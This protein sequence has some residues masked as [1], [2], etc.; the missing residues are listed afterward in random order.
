MSTSFINDPQC[1]S[2][3]SQTSSTDRP[4]LVKAEN[5][6][7]IFCRDLKKSLMYGLK[8]SLSDLA[9]V[10]K[11]A[12]AKDGRPLRNGEFWANKGISFEV[13]RG[14]C[15][16]LIGH[17][18]AGKTTLLKMLNG[19]IK[20][21]TGRVEISGR[22]GALIALGAGFNPILS[23]RENIYINGSVLGLSKE[24]IDK[25]IDDIIDFAEIHKFIDSPVQTYSSGMQVR[26]GFAVAVAIEPDVLI[27][28]EVTAVGDA[29]FRSKCFDRISKLRQKAAVIIVSHQEEIIKR[30]C[31]QV[32]LLD[33]GQI[34]ESGE[35]DKCLGIYRDRGLKSSGGFK[36]YC[37]GIVS[38]K[39]GLKKQ[40]SH[41][42]GDDMEVFFEIIIKNDIELVAGTVSFF[43]ET[44]VAVAT[45]DISQVITHLDKKS[46]CYRV[47]IKC[48]C[49]KSGW[50][51]IGLEL[52]GKSG[53]C[54]IREKFDMNVK[55][56]GGISNW[57][58]YTPTA[59]MISV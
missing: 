32:V 48:L 5:V 1:L 31:S 39:L 37:E 21:D 35:V 8:D 59:S 10:K 3:N 58:A 26:L 9:G 50:Y 23:G 22:V 46:R 55:I 14:E 44:G 6:G 15:L 28:D 33:D 38:V 25:K 49:L 20:P 13:K 34:V 18:G 45:S 2:L 42:S 11:G 52:I 7:K 51:K 17:N 56:E 27:L 54:V 43:D 41:L 19:L 36:Y 12:D 53:G 57:V 4:V 30:Y 40:A 29:Q 16:G 24:E 47:L